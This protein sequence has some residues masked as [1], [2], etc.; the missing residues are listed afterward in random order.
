MSGF[1]RSGF[2]RGFGHDRIGAGATV[3]G[4]AILLKGKREYL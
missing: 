4:M 2:G 3:F 1:G